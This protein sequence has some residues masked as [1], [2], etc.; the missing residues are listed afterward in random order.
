MLVSGVQQSDCYT[1]TYIHS[2]LIQASLPDPAYVMFPAELK[3]GRE[4]YRLKQDV[5][6]DET[7]LFWNTVCDFR[8]IKGTGL[9][10]TPHCC[11]GFKRCK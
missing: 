10:I 9:S 4:D 3:K 1:Y 5:N 11:F 2:F 8:S 6:T 7:S